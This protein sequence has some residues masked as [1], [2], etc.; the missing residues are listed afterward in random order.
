MYRAHRKDELPVLGIEDDTADAKRRVDGSDGEMVCEDDSD[1]QCILHAY[2]QALV[3]INKMRKGVADMRRTSTVLADDLVGLEETAN[4]LQA[5]V[6]SLADDIQ[7]F[8]NDL[9]VE[10]YLD[11]MIKRLV[12]YDEQIKYVPQRYPRREFP[13]GTKAL[14]ATTSLQMTHSPGALLS[15]TSGIRCS[16][17][18]TTGL[19]TKSTIIY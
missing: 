10:Y 19:A 3:R 13:V 11:D 8:N 16:Q 14:K 9:E 1:E 18:D 7:R 4:A 15:D 6:Q 2:V 17:S 5:G 12:R